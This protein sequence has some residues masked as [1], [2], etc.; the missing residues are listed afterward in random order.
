MAR[1]RAAEALRGRSGRTSR[2]ARRR[3]RDRRICGEVL[4]GRDDRRPRAA[5]GAHGDMRL[6]GVADIYAK[7]LKLVQELAF[8]HDRRPDV[9]DERRV[10]VVCH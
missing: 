2:R 7:S 6:C 3:A 5:V 1:R 9:L 4:Q 8:V 10:Y